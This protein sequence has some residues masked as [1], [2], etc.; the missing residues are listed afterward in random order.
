M[1]SRWLGRG[2]MFVLSEAQ[3]RNLLKWTRK[4]AGRLVDLGAGDGEVSRRFAHI[5]S[6]KYATEISWSMR[7]TL[8][9][10]GYTYVPSYLTT[11]TRVC[12]TLTL[13][14]LFFLLPL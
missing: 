13:A 5:Y 10:K 3:A 7:K 9:K 6:D 12:G 4:Q 14:D 11:K 1:N 2:S 8:A